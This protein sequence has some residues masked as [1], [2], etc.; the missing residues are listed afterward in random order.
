LRIKLEG[1]REV[2]NIDDG[3]TLHIVEEEQGRTI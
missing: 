2:K 3:G 1:K